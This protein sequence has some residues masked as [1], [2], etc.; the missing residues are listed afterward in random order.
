MTAERGARPTV[1]SWVK[2]LGSAGVVGDDTLFVVTDRD[3]RA[4]FAELH[5]CG[6]RSA[7]KQFGHGAMLLCGV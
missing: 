7:E 2:P 1:Q 4:S 5:D 6:A 3:E